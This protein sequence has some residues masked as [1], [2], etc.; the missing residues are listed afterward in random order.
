MI[1]FIMLLLILAAVLAL[2]IRLRQR[3]RNKPIIE[4]T[5]FHSISHIQSESKR[6]AEFSPTSV[7]TSPYS[8][9]IVDDQSAIRLLMRE[10]FELENIT[11]YEAPHGKAAIEQVLYHSIDY[12]LLD[13]K[14]PDM[15]GIE[16]LREIRKIDPTVMVAM[17][18]AYGDP[19]KLEAARELGVQSFFTKPFDIGHI[20]KFVMSKLME[21]D[22]RKGEIS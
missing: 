9:L 4:R 8:I 11:V 16:A 12:I 3:K 14:M 21:K 15:D 5:P 18:T 10:I 20:K 17:I 13:L 7:G 22:K 6:K 1:Y 19:D 2:A